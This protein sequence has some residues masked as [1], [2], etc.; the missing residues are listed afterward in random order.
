MI[1]RSIKGTILVFSVF[2]LGIVSGVLLT[3]LWDTMVDS[4]VISSNHRSAEHELGKFYEFVGLNVE[5]RSQ[6]SQIMQDSRPAFIK[7]FEQTR[8]LL[9]AMQKETRAQI[10]AILTEHQRKKYD[11]FNQTINARRNNQRPQHSN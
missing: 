2:F 4:A 1:D 10:R 7:V 8:P 6:V 11:E 5:Q 3:D 9:E